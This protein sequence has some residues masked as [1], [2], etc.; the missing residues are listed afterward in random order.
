MYKKK[1]Q[2]KTNVFDLANYLIEKSHQEKQ[3]INNTR[4]QKLLYYSQA[5]FLVKNSKQPLF[6]EPIEAWDY[7]PVIP[8]LYFEF[9]QFAYENLPL[10]QKATK[11]KLTEK[12]LKTLDFIFNKYKNQ[13]AN[14]LSQQ[15]HA[16]DPWQKRFQNFDF[17]LNRITNQ[18][19]YKY[20]HNKF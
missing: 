12:Q 11:N 4:L 13:S 6:N 16:E 15:T 10:S 5:Y 2:I 1:E 14:Q 19:L 7:G 9:R 17:S 3:E 20:F 18:D 8:D